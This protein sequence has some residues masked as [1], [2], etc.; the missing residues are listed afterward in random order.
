MEQLY[1]SCDGT[2]HNKP[3]PKEEWEK[4]W[5][6]DGK[7]RSLTVDAL[8]AAGFLV[9]VK[10]RAARDGS[11]SSGPLANYKGLENGK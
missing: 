1:V 6:E 3:M 5:N 11:R 10:K 8:I 2:P 4:W 7:I 9:P